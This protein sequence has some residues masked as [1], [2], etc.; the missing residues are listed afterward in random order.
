MMRST[1]IEFDLFA[2]GPW[3]YDVNSQ[4]IYEYWVSITIASK[5]KWYE[6]C[7]RS[8]VVI[9]WMER[10]A[11]SH[12][13]PCSLLGWEV[14][15][16]VR[17]CFCLLYPM[18]Y[19]IIVSTEPLTEGMDISLLE[20]VVSDQRQIL[21]DV[22]N[23][24]DITTIPQIWALYKEVEGYYDDGMRVPEDITLLWTDDKFVI[25]IVLTSHILW[26]IGMT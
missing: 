22:F 9:S 1:P 21:T 3:D 20:R 6:A 5:K 7:W 11:R 24:T 23:G 8:I 2:T 18:C 19:W 10:Y 14:P 15:V 12:M 26:L 16:M 25:S 13:N 4:E 17:F